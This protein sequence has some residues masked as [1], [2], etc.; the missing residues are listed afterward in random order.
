MASLNEHLQDEIKTKAFPHLEESFSQAAA[1]FA[2][3]ATNVS[4]LS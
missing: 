4:T 1:K 2:S 3:L